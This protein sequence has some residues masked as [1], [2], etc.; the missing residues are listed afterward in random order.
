MYKKLAHADFQLMSVVIYKSY[1][2]TYDIMFS[3]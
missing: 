1:T 3:S 2:K